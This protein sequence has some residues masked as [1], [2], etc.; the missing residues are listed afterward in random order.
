MTKEFVCEYISNKIIN[1]GNFIRITFYDI[2]VRN[3]LSA[4]EVDEFLREAQDILEAKDYQV[5]FT[6]AKYT[7]K[8]EQRVVQDNEYIIAIKDDENK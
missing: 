5:Y 6:N 4:D 1:E 3:N 8:H 7:Y 2:R